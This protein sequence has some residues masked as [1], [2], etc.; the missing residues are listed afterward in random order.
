MSS[1]AFINALRR[2]TTV[3]FRSARGTNFVG[4]TDDLKIDAIT[5]EDDIVKQFFF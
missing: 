4:A 5:V 1:S 3:R 2:F